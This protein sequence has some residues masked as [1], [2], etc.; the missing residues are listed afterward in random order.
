MGEKHGVLRKEIE[1]LFISETL[2]IGPDIKH[3]LCEE[4]LF[5][6]GTSKTQPRCIFVIFT[7]RIV[8]REILIRPISARYMHSKEI[9]RYEETIAKNKK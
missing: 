1:S 6:I 5:A 2:L 8:E 3:S 9:A 7:F 4:R